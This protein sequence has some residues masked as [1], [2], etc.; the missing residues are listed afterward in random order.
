MR[1]RPS[2]PSIEYRCD[3]WLVARP[4]EVM[5]DVP[6]YTLRC[7]WRVACRAAASPAS[8]YRDAARSWRAGPEAIPARRRPAALRHTAA[9]PPA[10]RAQPEPSR[11]SCC[12]GH[13]HSAGLA[14]GNREEEDAETEGEPPRANFH[15]LPEGER[16]FVMSE[17]RIP[18]YGKETKR[19]WRDSPDLIKKLQ[20]HCIAR[21]LC[22]IRLEME[23][24]SA[25]CS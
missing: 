1:G 15:Q 5:P 21:T 6:D 13:E 16:V 20:R 8:V 22:F 19:F 9:A 11:E 24:G 18:R 12:A 3:C 14:A 23:P 17:I 10:A 4:P 2:R 25:I 7:D